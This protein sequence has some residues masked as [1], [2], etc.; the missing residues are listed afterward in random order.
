MLNNWKSFLPSLRRQPGTQSP[1]SIIP[2]MMEDFWRDP[3]SNTLQTFPFF[4][5]QVYP[6]VDI[7]ETETEIVAKAE[8]PGLE[9]KEVDI[10]LRDNTLIIQGEK[11]SE[12]EE[13]KDNYHRIECSYGSFYRAIPLPVTVKEDGVKAK[14]DKGVLTISMIKSEKGN[15][16]K[17]QIE[18]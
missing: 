1:S 18:G 4:K 8:L 17:I 10:S 12:A 3:F 15:G 11:K 2:S 9:A 16:K 13:K 7:S 14:F 6:V 5:E